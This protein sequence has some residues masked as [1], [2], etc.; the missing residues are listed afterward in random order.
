[1]MNNSEACVVSR[2]LR[3][4]DTEGHW[5]DVEGR[6][7]LIMPRTERVSLEVDGVKGIMQFNHLAWS[8]PRDWADTALYVHKAFYDIAGGHRKVMD[9]LRPGA[10]FIT[11]LVTDANPFQLHA[12]LRSGDFPRSWI[13]AWLD[14]RELGKLTRSD[15][16]D[17]LRKELPYIQT[18][19]DHPVELT[20]A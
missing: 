16:V 11:E 5:H 15:L 17:A 12:A 10:S 2:Y 14:D 1:M 6:E 4:R 8:G 3:V 18:G 7:F 20:S 19:P 9:V 13:R